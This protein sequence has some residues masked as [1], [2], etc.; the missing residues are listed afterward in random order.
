MYKEYFVFGERLKEIIEERG[1]TQRELAEKAG[2]TEATISRYLSF[3]RV[4]K[5]THVLKIANALKCSC[6]YLLGK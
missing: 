1:M 4:P 6:D 5:A 3:Q 2:I